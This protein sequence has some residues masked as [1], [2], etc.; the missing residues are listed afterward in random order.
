LPYPASVS[1][2]YGSVLRRWLQRARL[3]LMVLLAGSLALFAEPVSR[4]VSIDFS[5]FDAQLKTR[6]GEDRLAVSALWQS[7]L[8]S[9][10]GQA[11]L[12]QVRQINAFFHEH[13]RYRLD[14][15]LYGAEDYWA[16]PLETLG[17]GL[18]DCEDYVIAKYISLLQAGV[19]D[20]KLRLVYVRARLGGPRSSTSRAHMVLSYQATPSAEPLILDSLIEDLLPASMRTDLDPVFSFNYQGMWAA[21]SATPL[22]SSTARLSRWRNVIERMESEGM[23]W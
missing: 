11:E 15:D 21:G 4:G 8:Y 17:H 2:A 10:Q 19:D 6:F 22:G 7:L 12:D 3:S 9:L 23:S 14:S 5:R 18:G 20:S 1:P 13:L 16:T